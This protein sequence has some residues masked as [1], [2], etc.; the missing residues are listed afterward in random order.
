MSAHFYACNFVMSAIEHDKLIAIVA[1]AIPFDLFT[2]DFF[3]R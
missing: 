2:F 1:I 3:E